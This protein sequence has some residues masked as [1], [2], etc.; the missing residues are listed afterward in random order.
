VS[1]I[2]ST[3]PTICCFKQIFEKRISVKSDLEK[4][5]MGEGRVWCGGGGG[6]SP[7]RPKF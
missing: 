3:Q 2:N 1:A 7:D 6:V 5:W 4:R